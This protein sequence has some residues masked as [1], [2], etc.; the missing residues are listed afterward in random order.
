MDTQE[1]IGRKVKPRSTFN[2]KIYSGPGKPEDEGVIARLGDETDF[3]G[4]VWV[5]WADDVE[6]DHLIIAE[7]V[8]PDDEYD[9]HYAV[10]LID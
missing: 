4:I 5:K 8:T 6:T 7:D 10:V 9:T 3:D 2:F 1:L